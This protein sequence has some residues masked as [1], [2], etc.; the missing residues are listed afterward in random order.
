[1]TYSYELAVADKM[2]SSWSLRGWLLFEA[3]AIPYKQHTARM[4]TD[5]FHEMLSAFQP[6]RLVPAMKFDGHVVTDSLAMAETLAEQNPSLN[7]WPADPAARALARSLS[8]E[9]HSGFGSLR[10]DC[11][12]NLRHSYPDYQ[13]SPDVLADVER[14]TKLWTLCRKTYGA[15]GPWLFGEYSIADV[16]YAPVATR[17]ATYNLP[18]NGVV[19]DYVAAHLAEPSFRRWRAMAF[20]QNFVQPG[21]D[22]DLTPAAWTGPTP[23][24]AKP[25]ENGPAENAICPYSDKPVLTHFLELEGRIFG[26]CNAFCRDKTVADAEAWEKFMAIYEI[27]A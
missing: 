13:P 20:A 7:M 3:F 5:G 15:N 18:Q 1:M 9:M 17:L 6:A 19:A 2:Y 24:A 10:T 11:T 22:L 14:I 4:Y 25:V 8:A 21:Y 26:F 16:F 12:M 23:L 27:A